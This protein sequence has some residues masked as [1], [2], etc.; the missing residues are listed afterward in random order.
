VAE[1]FRWRAS[2]QKSPRRAPR[3]YAVLAAATLIGLALNFVHIDPIRALFWAAIVN[4]V[5]SVPVMA[6]TMFM[7]G[8]KKVMGKF[9]IPIALKVIGWLATI[10]MLLA[11]IGLFATL[12]E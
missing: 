9:T 2:L 1:A 11:S 8:S 6:A 4:G 7:S 3:F 5:T 10:L 12:K